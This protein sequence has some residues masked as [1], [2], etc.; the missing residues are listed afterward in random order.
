MRF[1]A[2]FCTV[3]HK[4]KPVSVDLQVFTL[5]CF[6]YQR[7]VRDSNPGSPH[8][9]TRFPSARL[10]P[11]GQLSIKQNETDGKRDVN[12]RYTHNSLF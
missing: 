6:S 7:R 9:L 4:E 11:L 2:L 1:L 3:V 10:Q 12:S 5:F 8:E